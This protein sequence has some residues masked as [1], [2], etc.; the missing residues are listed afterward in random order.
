MIYD[1]K[2]I[3]GIELERTGASAAPVEGSYVTLICSTAYYDDMP[4][5]PMWFYHVNDN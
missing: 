1:C 3:L 4:N 2:T 5:R